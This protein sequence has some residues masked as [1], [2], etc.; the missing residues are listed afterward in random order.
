MNSYI[1]HTLYTLNITSPNE[2]FLETFYQKLID[3]FPPLEGFTY[4]CCGKEFQIKQGQLPSVREECPHCAA[5]YILSNSQ[6]VVRRIEVLSNYYRDCDCQITIDEAGF[7][8]LL[9]RNDVKQIIKKQSRIDWIHEKDYIIISN[10]LY[11]LFG[12]PNQYPPSIPKVDIYP[13]FGKPEI[14]FLIEHDLYD[15]FQQVHV[16]R[17]INIQK[18]IVQFLQ[19]IN[20]RIQQGGASLLGAF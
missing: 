14:D 6:N 8:N 19:E 9:K 2:S 16:I 12:M 7:Q 11:S 15:S 13:T 1:S 5:K 18:E 10:I 4:A 20:S 17:S 3:L